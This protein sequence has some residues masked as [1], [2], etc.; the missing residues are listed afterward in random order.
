MPLTPPTPY[1]TVADFVG[2]ALPPEALRLCPCSLGPVTRVGSGAG[3]VVPSGRLDVCALL[4]ATLVVRVEVLVGGAP[5][6]ATFRARVEAP[7]PGPWSAATTM[8]SSGS[9]AVLSDVVPT[10]LSLSFAGVF[11]AGDVYSFP[12]VSAVHHALARWN[13]RVAI[14]SAST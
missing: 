10:G 3:A 1:A 9:V 14:A 11:V 12:C 4:L 13:A 8:P 6:V 2:G 5:G 7:A